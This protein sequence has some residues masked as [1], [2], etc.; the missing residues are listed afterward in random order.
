VQ[1]AVEAFRICAWAGLARALTALFFLAFFAPCAVAEANADAME[2]RGYKM[3]GD[4]TRTRIVMRFDREPELKWFLLRAPHRLVIDLPQTRFAFDAQELSP[5]GLVT[6]VRYGSLNEGRSRVILTGKGP[7]KVEQISVLRNESS[8]GYRLVADIVASSEDVFQAA[9]AEQA[10]AIGS[11]LP[12]SKGDRPGK[13]PVAK[14]KAFTVVID[15][16]HGGIDSGA[17]GSNGTTEKKITLA[18]GLELKNKLEDAGGYHVVMTRETDEFL[19]LDDRVRIARQHGA[20]LFISVHADTIR[21][22]WLRGATVY[23]MSETASD[24]EAAATAARENLADE[25]AGMSLD[26]ENHEVADIL[27]DLVRRE[28][29]GFS[30]RFARSLVGE[31]SDSVQLINNP[32]RSAGFKVLK[33]PDV[34]SVLLELGYLSNPKDEEQLRD[35][36][37]RNR[38]VGSVFAAIEQFA[39]ARLRAGG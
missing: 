19:R 11:T 4:A 16:G 21:H 15:P 26:D 30:I 29:H 14:R 6:G 17:K 20:D 35:A 33:A 34:P 39:A 2:A 24:A 37:W 36:A 8:P 1:T 23:T 27:V 7:F 5:R 32:H 31:L 9:L 25:I 22:K 28:T 13:S 38:A 3:A 12:A 10:A 18:F